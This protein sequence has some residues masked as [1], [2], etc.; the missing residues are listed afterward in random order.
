MDSF[1]RLSEDNQYVKLVLDH[2]KHWLQGKK[3]T[4]FNIMELVTKLIPQTQKVMSEKG[5]GPMKKKVIMSVLLILVDKLNFPSEE[6]KNQ[7]KGVIEETVPS[8]IDLM[9]G[10]SKGDIDFQKIVKQS[11]KYFK[12]FKS[13]C[14]SKDQKD[15]TVPTRNTTL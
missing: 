4:T 6:E 1:E 11:S 9:I 14:G 3:L 5:L 12:I 8:S 15:N 7:I 13:C 10:I 2:S